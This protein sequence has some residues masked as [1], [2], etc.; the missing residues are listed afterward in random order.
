MAEK[1]TCPAD[2]KFSPMTYASLLKVGASKRDVLT[3]PDWT[4][5]FLTLFGFVILIILA[6]LLVSYIARRNW[7]SSKAPTIS[8]QI[9]NYKE[10]SRNDPEDLKSIVSINTDSSSFMF[11]ATA[12]G[13]D[14]IDIDKKL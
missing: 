11:R 4:F 8:Y 13:D 6:V 5:F 7:K 12:G 9:G 2:S 3:P 14:S 10:V 1:Q